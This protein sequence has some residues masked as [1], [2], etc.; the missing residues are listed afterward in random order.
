MGTSSPAVPVGW[1]AGFGEA[2]A[3]AKHRLALQVLAGCLISAAEVTRVWSGQG[4]RRRRRRK[5]PGHWL[6]QLLVQ[7]QCGRVGGPGWAA[8]GG[9]SG[10]EQSG[11]HPARGYVE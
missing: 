2:F 10:A 9:G 6:R 7:N 11:G 8:G 3:C 4:L 1:S 5:G